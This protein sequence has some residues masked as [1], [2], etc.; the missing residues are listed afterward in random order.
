M[1]AAFIG[2]TARV[3]A[4]ASTTPGAPGHVRLGL[5]LGST[6]QETVARFLFAAAIFA[7]IALPYFIW[8][9]KHDSAQTA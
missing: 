5:T 9:W 2:G 8:K 6:L 4:I 7:A 3:Q 1:F